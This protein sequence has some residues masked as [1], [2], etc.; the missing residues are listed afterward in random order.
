LSYPLAFILL[1]LGVVANVSE[2][3]DRRILGADIPTLASLRATDPDA[4]VV[5]AT[6]S[7]LSRA[8]IDGFLPLICKSKNASDGAIEVG[9]LPAL[10][11]S[12]SSTKSAKGDD[13]LKRAKHNG[14]GMKLE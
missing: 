1:N 2:D 9:G 10:K 7:P 13:E 6:R 12:G 3:I 4:P 8:T 11:F 5:V 14:R